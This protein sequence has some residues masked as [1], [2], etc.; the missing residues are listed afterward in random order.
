MKLIIWAGNYKQAKDYAGERGITQDEFIYLY[1]EQD[2]HGLCGCALVK[3]G[4]WY[5][6]SDLHAE[7]IETYAMQHGITI[8]T[9]KAYNVP[10]DAVK[11][12]VCRARCH[13][14]LC[15]QRDT[16]L[17]ADPNICLACGDWY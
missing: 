12:N 5:M 17:P 9:P 13:N 10:K 16:G 11:S 4:T 6:R 3:V 2:I 15:T 8:V 1:K 7:F 14:F